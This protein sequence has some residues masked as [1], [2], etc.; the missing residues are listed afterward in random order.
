M[1]AAWLPTQRPGG[2]P[3]TTAS[4]ESGDLGLD[5]RI[6][7]LIAEGLP[8]SWRELATGHDGMVLAPE[9]L[10]EVLLTLECAPV[11]ARGPRD[12][13]SA[14]TSVDLQ[15]MLVGLDRKC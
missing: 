2:P 1:T 13:A 6:A 8:W 5:G 12:R 9:A 15:A 4:K 10:A 3:A 11:T 14:R 7:Q